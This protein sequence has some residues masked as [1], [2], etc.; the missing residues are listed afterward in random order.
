MYVAG[1]GIEPATYGSSVFEKWR[2]LQSMGEING[3]KIDWWD[4]WTTCDFTSF[5]IVFQSYQDNGQMISK[6]AA[7]AQRN[8][9]YG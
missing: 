7:R 1:P 9:V 6:A 2:R 8:P 5:A 3:E 4:G